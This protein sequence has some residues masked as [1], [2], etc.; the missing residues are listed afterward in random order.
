MHA[1]LFDRAEEPVALF[2]KSVISSQEPIVRMVELELESISSEDEAP[3]PMQSFNR[4]D[5]L[6][7]VP[8]TGEVD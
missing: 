8:K 6:V 7:L 1:L 5:R 3:A 2:Q 4:K